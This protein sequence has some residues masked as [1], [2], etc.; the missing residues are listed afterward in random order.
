MRRGLGWLPV[1][2]LAAAGCADSSYGPACTLIGCEDG[3]AVDIE[4]P[5]PAAY[6]VTLTA[7]GQSPVVFQCAPAAECIRPLF[8][9]GF[10]PETVEVRVEADGI[11]V[12]ETFEPA[13]V[14]SRPNG[15]LCPPECRQAT[16][17]V[18]VR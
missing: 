4:G 3:L 10:T 9:G 2:A 17:V 6:T 1:L 8:A 14:V 13:Y 11:D 5:L 7:P 16:V 18:D 15:A 12:R